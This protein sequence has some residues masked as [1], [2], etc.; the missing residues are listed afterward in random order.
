MLIL[1]KHRMPFW[2]SFCLLMPR[3]AYLGG[4]GAG[5]GRYGALEAL[6]GLG[7]A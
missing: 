4:G 7:P 1:N 6:G 2:V 5:A 3:S